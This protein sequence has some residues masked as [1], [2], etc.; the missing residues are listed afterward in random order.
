[1]RITAD[2]LMVGYPAITV[3]NFLRKYEIA[4]LIAE[5]TQ[6]SLSLSPQDA[7]EFLNLAIYLTPP[8]TIGCGLTS[9]AN[10]TGPI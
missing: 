1:M 3:R 4:G 5:C 8:G 7:S 2:Q 10:G 9:F 6:A